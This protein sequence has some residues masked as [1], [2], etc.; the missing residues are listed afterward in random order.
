MINEPS[1]EEEYI[2]LNKA[3]D[4]LL[5]RKIRNAYIDKLELYGLRDGLMDSLISRGADGRE[6]FSLV[7]FEDEVSRDEVNQDGIRV[8]QQK[9]SLRQYE[10]KADFNG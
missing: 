8:Q 4:D 1:R 3:R 10:F 6:S 5:D 2:L 7:P 9:T